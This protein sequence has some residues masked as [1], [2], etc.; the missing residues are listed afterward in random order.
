MTV[1][2]F[3]FGRILS[4]SYT[5]TFESLYFFELKL[6]SFRN[7]WF[8]IV[9]YIFST[10][11]QRYIFPIFISCKI[12]YII[13]LIEIFFIILFAFL[14]YL[15][16]NTIKTVSVIMFVSMY[17]CIYFSVHAFF[18]Y[19]HLIIFKIILILFLIKFNLDWSHFFLLVVFD[20]F[21]T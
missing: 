9:F 11:S 18:I 3:H 8:F 19:L 12:I 15:A 21:M 2:P 17:V 14:I 13:I 20:K 5:N 7:N 6:F 1:I 16:I 10:D 4:M